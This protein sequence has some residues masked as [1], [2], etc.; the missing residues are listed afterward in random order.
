MVTLAG[1]TLL[2]PGTPLDRAWALN[3]N[4]YQ[5]LTSIRI[6]AGVLFLLLSVLLIFSAVGWFRRRRWGWILAVLII[7]V[8][9]IGDLLNVLRGDWQ[10]GTVGAILEGAL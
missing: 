2:L 3:P 5:Q 6:I 1:T 7:S 4:A 10:R 9:V 8:Q